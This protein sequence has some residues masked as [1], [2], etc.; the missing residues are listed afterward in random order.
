[1][2]D[3]MTAIVQ[4]GVGREVASAQKPFGIQPATAAFG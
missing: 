1:M 2:I 4:W 3:T